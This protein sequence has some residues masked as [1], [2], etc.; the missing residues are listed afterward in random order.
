MFYRAY[1]ADPE[2]DTSGD[3]GYSDPALGR[4]HGRPYGK[5]KNT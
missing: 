4:S 5:G 3:Y 1:P 2:F